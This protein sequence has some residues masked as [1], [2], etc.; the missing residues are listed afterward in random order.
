MEEIILDFT[1]CK[2][3]KST[4]DLYQVLKDAFQFPF[5][6]GNNSHA[7][8]DSMWYMWED[9]VHFKI[10][11]TSELEY[12]YLQMEMQYILKV[13]QRVHEETPNV[14]FEVIS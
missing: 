14:T 8:W 4:D 9:P 2:R 6:F 10:Y 3:A 12:Q 5:D 7:L 11:G 13:F 1:K